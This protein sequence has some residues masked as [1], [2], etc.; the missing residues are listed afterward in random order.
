M[1]S[2]IVS[3]ILFI[4]L[5]WFHLWC[6]CSLSNSGQDNKCNEKLPEVNW[7]QHANAHDNFSSQKKFLSSNFLFS[8]EGQKPCIEGSMAMRYITPGYCLFFSFVSYLN[9]FHSHIS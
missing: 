7:S 4:Y 5:D 8:L 1:H 6:I 3:F 2:T 9:Y